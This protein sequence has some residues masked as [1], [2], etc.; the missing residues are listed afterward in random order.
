MSRIG[1][2]I[3][4]IPEGVQ[5]IANDKNVV[6]IKGPK[7]EIQ[8]TID[9]ILSVKIEDGIIEVKRHSEQKS[10]KAKHGLYRALLYNNIIGVT[11]GYTKKMELV[12]VG[13]RVALSGQQL[14]FSLGF[15]HNIVFELPSEIKIDVV[16]ERGKN[17]LLTLE[18]FDKELLGLVAAKI[19]SFRP[20]EPYK[21]K[22][23]RFVGQYIR[24]KAGKAAAAK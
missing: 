1:K 3:I 24:R 7:G 6:D 2:A 11:E 21:G 8:L 14:D 9:S 16:T 22:G 23:I 20:P 18:S 13:Y 10:H 19:Q 4:K 5:A 17:P 15:S 12:G